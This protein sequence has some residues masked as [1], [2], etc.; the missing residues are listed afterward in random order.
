MPIAKLRA[1]AVEAIPAL[2]DGECGVEPTVVGRTRQLHRRAARDCRSF[3]AARPL[4]SC[5]QEVEMGMMTG[6]LL[7]GCNAGSN[8]FEQ[9]VSDA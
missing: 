3:R 9:G 7:V 4:Q 8:E 5:P 6:E 2:S 1:Q